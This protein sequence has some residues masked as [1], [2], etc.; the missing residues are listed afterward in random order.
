MI[1]DA[2][3]FTD[4]RAQKF[5]YDILAKMPDSISYSL[6]IKENGDIHGLDDLVGQTVATLGAP[7]L[8]ATR[9]AAIFANPARQPIITNVAT[10]DE[11]I[12]KLTQ[13]KI[14]AA[15][16][17]STDII[18]A[19]S[20]LANVR[21]IVTTEPI[22]EAAIS[23]SPRLELSIRKAIQIALLHAAKTDDGRD[24]L[25]QLSITGFSPAT[26][27]LYAGYSNALKQYWGY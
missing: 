11:A 21:V 3:H 15:F 10:T 1:L 20:R 19:W 25:A 26:S 24:M 9:L 12:E 18:R 5:G 23:A 13:G 27:Q 22:P 8:G 16:L 14:H 4:Y 2:A 7:S 17:P 6:I